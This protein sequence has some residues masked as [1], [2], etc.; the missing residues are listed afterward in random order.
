M[1]IPNEIV[2]NGKTYDVSSLTEAQLLYITTYLKVSQGSPS[3]DPDARD[4]DSR[5][6]QAQRMFG[7][8]DAVS[9]IQTLIDGFNNTN[10]S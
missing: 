7:D 9:S 3:N 8:L 6:N 10:N 1:S 2:F 4:Y 5:M